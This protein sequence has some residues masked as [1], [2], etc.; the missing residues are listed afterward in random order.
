M[1]P[2]GFFANAEITQD[3]DGQED[4]RYSAVVDPTD[5]RINLQTPQLFRTP[6][7]SALLQS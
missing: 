5:Y 7:F 1:I 4:D 2:T 3:S 6:R